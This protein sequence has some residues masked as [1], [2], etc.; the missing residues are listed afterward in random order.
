MTDLTK[1][2]RGYFRGFDF[3]QRTDDCPDAMYDMIAVNNELKRPDRPVT[4]EQALYMLEHHF[5]DPQG[6]GLHQLCHSHSEFFIC[7]NFMLQNHPEWNTGDRK[8]ILRFAM[9]K[10]GGR[11]NPAIISQWIYQLQDRPEQASNQPTDE[12]KKEQK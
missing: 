10:F 7:L 1:N 8:E 9:K 12:N 6:M 11:C 4:D 5:F 3:D 2:L